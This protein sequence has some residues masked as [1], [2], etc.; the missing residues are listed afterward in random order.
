MQEEIHPNF[1]HQVTKAQI[2][3]NNKKNIVAVKFFMQHAG[4]P[5]ST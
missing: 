2:N 4:A 5:Y 3:T 1:S